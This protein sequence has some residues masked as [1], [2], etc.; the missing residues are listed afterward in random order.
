MAGRLGDRKAEN[1]RATGAQACFI[2][3]VGCLMQIARHLK[4][5][6]PEVWCAH[7][8]DAL[9]ASYSGELPA[10]ISS[11]VSRKPC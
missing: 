1:I 10:E 2:G 3:N 9:W 7:P 4:S 11:F 5:V 6:A 8:V